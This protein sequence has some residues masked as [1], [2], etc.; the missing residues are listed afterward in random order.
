ME[1]LVGP[2]RWSEQLKKRNT[3]I[4]VRILD[5]PVGGIGAILTT[6]SQ[7][8]AFH[9]RTGHEGSAMGTI[10]HGKKHCTHCTG[11]GVGPRTSCYTSVMKTVIYSFTLYMHTCTVCMH[12]CTR[13]CDCSD[14]LIMGLQ[15][16]QHGSFN[17]INYWEHSIDTVSLYIYIYIL[18]KP[19]PTTYLQ[20]QYTVPYS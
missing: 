10:T 17:N 6:L 7:P 11:G 19:V 12:V 20:L 18:K 15:E 5:Y 13:V 8:G 3:C 16:L 2:Q 4:S 1:G 9:P 14:S